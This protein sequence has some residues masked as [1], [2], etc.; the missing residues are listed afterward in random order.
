MAQEKESEAKKEYS[1]HKDC[2]LSGFDGICRRPRHHL[3]ASVLWLVD[4]NLRKINRKTD[5]FIGD[6]NR[7]IDHVQAAVEAEYD[8]VLDILKESILANYS[9]KAGQQEANEALDIVDLKEGGYETEF[10]RHMRL[11]NFVEEKKLREYK[12]QI[13]DEKRR[14]RTTMSIE[15]LIRTQI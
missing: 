6:R 8:E 2:A 11:K 9:E 5:F 3:I 12:E 4:F 13:E 14:M 7:K 10:E 15:D 1:I